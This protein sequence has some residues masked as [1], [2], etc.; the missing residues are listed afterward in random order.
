MKT[1]IIIS[2]FIL[3][4]VLI[5]PIGIDNIRELDTEQIIRETLVTNISV[6]STNLDT[7]FIPQGEIVNSSLTFATHI[8]PILEYTHLCIYINDVL[9]F[10]GSVSSAQMILI[11]YNA[12]TGINTFNA[13]ISNPSVNFTSIDLFLKHNV[14]VARTDKTT[15]LLFI[16]QFIIIIA[17]V[18]FIARIMKSKRF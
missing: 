13:V 9:T 4:F 18:L 2:G 7:F 6:G 15:Q 11:N 17:G 5:A 8:N 10:T 16:L 14:T 12:T 1:L 3:L